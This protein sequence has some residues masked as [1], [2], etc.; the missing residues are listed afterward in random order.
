MPIVGVNQ[1]S[2]G[3][4]APFATCAIDPTSGLVYSPGCANY[5][6]ITTAG[7]STIKS[8]G[9]IFYGF[10]AVANGTSFTLTPYDVYVSVTGTTTS[11]T[12]T[13]MYPTSTAG[14]PSSTVNI[15]AG[16][17][18]VR[19]NGQLLAVTAGTPGQFNVLWD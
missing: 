8:G 10:V 15:T 12:T 7:T 16:A 17:A 2:A 11:T 14:T 19:F 1:T 3:N 5:T 9:G 18:G 13:Q 6:A 4:A